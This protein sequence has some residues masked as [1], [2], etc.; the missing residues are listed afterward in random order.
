M[1]GNVKKLSN[2]APIILT[3]VPRVHGAS[4]PDGTNSNLNY[5]EIIKNHKLKNKEER[6]IYLVINGPGFEENQI[7][8]LKREL[9]EIEG[10]HVLDLHQCDW[11]EIDTGWKIDGENISIKDFFKNMYNMT[12]EQ[13]M[14]FA[15]EID[16]FRLIALA[17]LKQFT[18]HE[19]GIY[20]DFDSL[21]AI[22]IHIGKDITIPEGILLGAVLVIP[23]PNSG[24]IIG[25]GLNND[26]IAI[27]DSSVA[28]NILSEYKDKILSQKEMCSDVKQRLPLLM[29]ELL[30]KEFAKLREKKEIA[31]EQIEIIEEEIKKT[32]KEGINGY[33]ND[34]ENRGIVA[35]YDM[36]PQNFQYL[37]SSYLG[38][39]STGFNLGH[40][41]I[42]KVVNK[43]LIGE[44][45]SRWKSFAFGKNNGNYICKQESDMSWMK[46]EDLYHKRMDNKQPS[47]PNKNN[48]PA[49]LLKDSN[50]EVVMN[51]GQEL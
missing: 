42:Q 49:N 48:S 35:L 27:N 25:T 20:I 11:S 31:E 3:W 28:A 13:R 12:D 32:T 16:T 37:N 21:K 34:L 15:V 24:R 51:Q 6:D 4:L 29:D 10:I 44:E 26:L 40:I 1:I 46:V 43:G 39:S 19:G 2:K 5:L 47:D 45:V 14:Y 50:T 17:L 9:K 23:D 30:D 22:D 36:Q 7:D 18:E 8:D 33:I 38:C 41:H